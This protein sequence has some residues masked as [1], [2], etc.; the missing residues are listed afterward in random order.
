MFPL[1]NRAQI[2]RYCAIVRNPDQTCIFHLRDSGANQTTMATKV[3]PYC[4]VE[5]PVRQ[6][7]HSGSSSRVS[8]EQVARKIPDYF[9][10]LAPG[11]DSKLPPVTRGW[12]S[13]TPA[14]FLCFAV[15]SR[16]VA[17]ETYGELRTLIR[18]LQARDALSADNGDLLPS[19]FPL[20]DSLCV[21]IPYSD[22]CV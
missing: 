16:S 6:W 13:D 20:D 21:L 8:S 9:G 5:A 18:T 11:H 10:I 4:K 2:R 15:F 22:N 12:S 14:S 19:A 1:D 3:A 7:D 17:M